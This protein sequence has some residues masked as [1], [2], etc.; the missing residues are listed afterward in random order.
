MPSNEML[1]EF[2]RLG[3]ITGANVQKGQP[4]VIT[5]PVEAYELVRECTKVAYEAGASRVI[6]D[7]DDNPI[8]RYHFEYMS[9]EELSDFPCWIENRYKY[10][11]DKGVCFLHIL[12]EDP[13][14]LEGI[15]PNKIRTYRMARMRAMEKFQHYT[16]NNEAQWS[17]IAY[18]NVKWAKKIFPDKSDEE[19]VEALWDAIFMTSRVEINKTVENWDKHNKEVKNHSDILNKYN[20]KSLHFKNARGTDLEVGL[21]KDHIWEGGCEH[22]TG[23]VVFNPNIP[24]EEVFTMPDRRRINGTV[25]STKPL[26]YSGNVIPE[27]KLV[28]KDGVVVD[29]DAPKNKEFLKDLLEID[30]G[31]KSLGEVALISYDSP[32]SNSNI[33]FYET[34]FDENASCH[35][36]LGACYPS[37]VKGGIELS[38]E[39]LYELGG[40]YSMNHEDFMFGSSDM[41]IVGTTYDG[42]E[43]IVFENGNFAF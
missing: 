37:N 40:N 39:E 20:F 31:A 29:Y 25:Y 35:L 22:T 3:V 24:T 42:K 33:L 26:V 18:P 6:V 7:Y 19:A 8:S 11:I 41:K 12:S 30:G 15:D 10:Y 14:L 5:A 27:F 32:I 1:K 4:I 17:L 9:E 38:R 13:D 28:F 2:A 34:L 36:A 21:I 23:D 16:M 43:V